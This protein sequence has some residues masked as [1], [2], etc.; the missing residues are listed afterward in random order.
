MDT[1]PN[2]SGTLA[3]VIGVDVGTSGLR[4]VAADIAGNLISSNER[5]ILSDTRP[6]PTLH[7]QDPNEWWRET[8]SA[9][10]QLTAELSQSGSSP[11]IKGIAVTSTSGSLIIADESGRPLRQAILYDD[12]RTV[13]VA[14]ELNRKAAAKIVD[15][16]YSLA[17]ALWI[18]EQEPLLWETTR[19]LLHPADWLAGKLTGEFGHSDYSDALKLGYDPEA[20]RWSDA[21]ALAG[22]PTEMLPNVHSPGQRMG[23]VSSVA[24]RET[25]LAVGI[26]VVAGATDGIA[27]LVASGATAAGDAN[28]TLG[29]TLVWK[30][31]S[32]C[33][34]AAVGGIYSHLHPTGLWAPGAAS[35]TGP[36]CLRVEGNGD[37]AEM[38]RQAATV[39]PTSLVCY[40]LPGQGER[41]PFSNNQATTF[42]E[43]PRGDDVEW[44]AAQLQ[45]IAF[46]E[47][48]G[49]EVLERAGVE[50]KGQV[51]STGGAAASPVF[52]QLRANVLRRTVIRSRYP[53]SAFGAAILAAA[54]T[55]FEGNAAAAIHSMTSPAETH[56]PSDA[57]ARYEEIYTKFRM[58]CSERGYA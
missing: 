11:E 55:L 45:S 50:V 16:S 57:A 53:T 24:A 14:E 32:P 43:G 44:Y 9:L 6:A 4:A 22:I 26:P 2:R 18:R 41:F 39:L 58:A 52:S 40:L 1:Q 47:R 25:G 23:V 31:L 28:T 27:S 10:R 20:K 56:D 5:P 33:K 46:A 48:W 8:C 42:V 36:G 37:R 49:Y 51:Y 19:Y 17:R 38:D 15:A 3:V 7:E 54:G 35:N 30:A 34:P 12:R 21:V 13:A 29:T